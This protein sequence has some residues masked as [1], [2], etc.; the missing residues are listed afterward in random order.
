[1]SIL[2]NKLASGFT[3]LSNNIITDNRIS[4]H[5]FRVYVYLASKPNGW[6]VN[7]QD[8]QTKLNIKRRETIAG[9]WKE[10]ID[11][12]YITR[13]TRLSANGNP[14]GSY[15]YIINACTVIPCTVE[16]CTVEPDMGGDHVRLNST[17]PV[18]L[19]STYSNTNNKTNNT[20]TTSIYNFYCKVMNVNR[21]A[22]HDL[23]KRINHYITEY[24]CSLVDIKKMI[25]GCRYSPYHMGDNPQEKA[26]NGLNVI[27]DLTKNKYDL[28]MTSYTEC[29]NDRDWLSIDGGEPRLVGRVGRNKLITDIAKPLTE[30]EV[31][32]Y[33]SKDCK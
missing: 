5:A 33:L 2:H 20:I 25:I 12:G 7:N 29:L 28:F 13:V 23:D 24:Q 22:P 4:S 9:Y 14:T 10:L 19:N 21:K 27:L 32:E 26:Y 1:M 16:A 18:R 6:N 30:E 31:D 3:M 11:N 8:V 15:D 17:D